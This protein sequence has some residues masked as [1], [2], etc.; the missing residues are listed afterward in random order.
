M[1]RCG[2]ADGHDDNW[3]ASMISNKFLLAEMRDAADAQR[4]ELKAIE[5]ALDMRAKR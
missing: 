5:D 1:A 3:H 2:A 4:A